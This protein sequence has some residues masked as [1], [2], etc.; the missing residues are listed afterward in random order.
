M[1]LFPLR[2]TARFTPAFRKSSDS[3]IVNCRYDHRLRSSASLRTISSVWIAAF[4]LI[5]PL[6]PTPLAFVS[7]VISLSRFPLLFVSAVQHELAPSS[8]THPRDH[9]AWL[10]GYRRSFIVLLSVALRPLLQ[11]L[12]GTN[13]SSMVVAVSIAQLRQGPRRTPLRSAACF[14]SARQTTTTVSFGTA[15]GQT[16]DSHRVFPATGDARAVLL[17]VVAACFNQRRTLASQRSRWLKHSY[18]GAAAT[19]TRTLVLLASIS[20]TRVLPRC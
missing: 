7:C 14:C 16:Q 13:T 6:Y 8:T 2:S 4:L 5:H 17:T 9:R 20:S 10:G 1:S 12:H 11:I 3:I 15:G 19:T 18:S